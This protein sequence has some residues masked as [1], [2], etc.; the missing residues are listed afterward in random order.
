MEKFQMMW[1][2]PTY[3]WMKKLHQSE[4][5]WKNKIA[6]LGGLFGGS[7]VNW[8]LSWFFKIKKTSAG[9]SQRI[10]ASCRNLLMS[11][12]DNRHKWTAKLDGS[13][14]HI[15]NFKSSKKVNA[16]KLKLRIH[17]CK[18]RCIK[19]WR[20]T[21]SHHFEIEKPSA[22]I[23]VNLFS[24]S[25]KIVVCFSEKYKIDHPKYS[26]TGNQAFGSNT[27]FRQQN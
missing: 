7:C 14:Y 10:S 9:F 21:A 15:I 20:Q 16:L 27:Q 25:S 11:K 12:P 3:S 6:L 17:K 24:W 1:T 23:F 19:T 5:L 8:K 26:N 18:T 13:I 22:L 4:L 2:T